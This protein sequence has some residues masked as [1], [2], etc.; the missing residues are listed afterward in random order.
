VA[1]VTL[2]AML[3]HLRGHRASSLRHCART[4]EDQRSASKA[5]AKNKL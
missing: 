5:A 2:V 3:E 1:V 4:M